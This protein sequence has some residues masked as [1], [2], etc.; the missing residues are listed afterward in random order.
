MGLSENYIATSILAAI[1][2]SLNDGYEKGFEA[3]QQAAREARRKTCAER[4]T[5]SQHRAVVAY[6]HGYDSG[7]LVGRAEGRAELFDEMR[8]QVEKNNHPTDVSS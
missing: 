5:S 4:G 6:N 3:G 2:W 1:E 7:L 8:R